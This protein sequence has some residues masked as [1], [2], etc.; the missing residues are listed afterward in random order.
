MFN[1]E[2]ESWKAGARLRR[3]PFEGTRQLGV[4]TVE[5][6][7]GINGNAF[8]GN[9]RKGADHFALDLIKFMKPLIMDRN[10]QDIGQL[11]WE[12]WKMNRSVSTRIIG[13]ID[14]C[15]WD[16]NGKI[17]LTPKEVLAI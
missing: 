4:V 13:A 14:V 1:W 15:L 17:N 12:M 6:D 3:R 9:S 2:S 8:L 5:T 7:V 11:W 10:P 16:I